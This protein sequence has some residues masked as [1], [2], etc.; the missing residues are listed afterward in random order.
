MGAS[1]CD[2]ARVTSHRALCLAFARGSDQGTR[3]LVSLP[4]PLLRVA[5]HVAHLPCTWIWA[6]FTAVRL[7]CLSQTTLPLQNYLWTLLLPLHHAT[8]YA[9][10]S[11]LYVCCNDEAH[12]QALQRS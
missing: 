6:V 1:S 2:L 12:A 9:A 10:H 5:A 8:L 3:I 4:R 7:S 11:A